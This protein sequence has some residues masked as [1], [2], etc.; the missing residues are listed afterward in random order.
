MIESLV[1]RSP[2]EGRVLAPPV[3][4]VEERTAGTLGTWRGSPLEVRNVGAWIEAG[5]PL[6]VVAEDGGW[7]AWAGVEQA[8]VPAVEV[9]QAARVLIDQHPTNISS[10]KVVEV[11]R[12]SRSNKGRL[13]VHAESD[14][15]LGDS[16][17]HVVQIALDA[18]PASLLPGARGEVKIAT[19]GSTV[20]RLVLDEI[21]RTFQRV[22]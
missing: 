2:A 8:D 18:P 12:R 7:R 20:G 11:S 10:G 22:F 5:T 6:A 13:A 1:I 15:S 9:G 21:R 16:A 17:Y 3:R 19:Y 4:P 14:D